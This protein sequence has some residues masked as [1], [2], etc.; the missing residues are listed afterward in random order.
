MEVKLKQPK[1]YIQQVTKNVDVFIL[2]TMDEGYIEN[3]ENNH[4][5]LHIDEHDE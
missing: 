4:Y 5:L 3:E 2:E 1:L